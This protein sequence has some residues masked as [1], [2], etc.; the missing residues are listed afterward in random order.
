MNLE[1]NDHRVNA[2]SIMSTIMIT[3]S[4]G[5]TNTIECDSE[6]GAAAMDELVA[7]INDKFGEA[8]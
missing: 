8:V 6:D 4:K 2:K 7:M 5:S 1:R 3:A